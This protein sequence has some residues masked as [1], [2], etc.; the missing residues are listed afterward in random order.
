[1][2]PFRQLFRG[3]N[4]MNISRIAFYSLLLIGTSGC[5]RY[6]PAVAPEKMAPA[7]AQNFTVAPMND[8]VLFAFQS[9]SDDV[10]GRPLKSLEGY[11][12]YKKNLTQDDS[13]IFRKEGYNLVTA[14]LDNHLAALTELQD[15]AKA[16]GKNPNNVSVP[17]SLTKF[18]YKDT[19]LT[20]GQSYAYRLVG[21]NQ[22][23]VEAEIDRVVQIDFDGD[24]S[25]I[26]QLR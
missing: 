24:N 2:I 14:I 26:T 23:G 16:S 5:G 15:R 7:P 21:F 8:G 18:T 9:S 22:G 3:L 11:R 6:V 10:R 4:G 20:R 12:L 25:T 17:P 1:V 19:S 13:G